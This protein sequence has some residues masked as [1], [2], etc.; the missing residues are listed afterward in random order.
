MRLRLVPAVYPHIQAPLFM[1]LAA[2]RRGGGEEGGGCKRVGIYFIEREDVSASEGASPG[3]VAWCIPRLSCPRVVGIEAEKGTKASIHAGGVCG[4]LHTAL[5]QSC[6]KTSRAAT[7]NS[8]WRKA[9]P[10]RD[11]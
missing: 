6:G 4:G 2:G 5:D 7:G 1:L 8:A 11:L 9:S 10:Q 3:F